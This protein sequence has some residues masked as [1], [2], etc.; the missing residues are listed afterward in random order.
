M[1]QVYSDYYV[2]LFLK[3]HNIGLFFFFRKKLTWLGDMT[4]TFLKF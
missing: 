2:V 1:R 3:A 4:H